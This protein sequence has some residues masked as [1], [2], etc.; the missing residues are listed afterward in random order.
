VHFLCT[1]SIC[2]DRKPG[3]ILN[4]YRYLS[5]EY[6]ASFQESGTQAPSIIGIFWEDWLPDALTI[7]RDAG[8]EQDAVDG[9]SWTLDKKIA[10]KF[11]RRTTYV[12][13]FRGSGRHDTVKS[14][15]SPGIIFKGY[16]DCLRPRREFRSLAK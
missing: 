12:S 14:G 15:N 2:V 16:L 6:R 13:I 7:Y 9:F 5:I 8:S 3:G 4:R 10:A 11:A 1:Y